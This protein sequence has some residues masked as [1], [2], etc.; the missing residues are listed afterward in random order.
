[1]RIVKKITGVLLIVAGLTDAVLFVI[2]AISFCLDWA[3][4][5]NQ[6]GEIF[7]SLLC[8]IAGGAV[9]YGGVRLF[10]NG[11]TSIPIKEPVILNHEN[12]RPLT[13]KKFTLNTGVSN[14][15][16]MII[17]DVFDIDNLGCVVTGVLKGEAL[18]LQDNV[19][20]L[21]EN[22]KKRY[23]Q[24]YQ[25]EVFQGEKIMK[26]TRVMGDSGNRVGLL[27]KGMLANSV[28]LGDVLTSVTPNTRDV[29]QPIENPRLKGLLTGRSE[30]FLTDLE[31]RIQREISLANFLV[32][33]EFDLPPVSNEDGTAKLTKDT[34]MLF[35]YLTA[36][37]GPSYQPV[38]TD[39]AELDKW[40]TGKE[41]KRNT[42]LMSADEVKQMLHSN[43]N[44]V[45]YVINPFSDN[46]IV[47]TEK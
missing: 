4:M 42:I 9:A 15:Y 44:L 16:T 5:G 10:K 26:A 39:H 35:P 32:L 38:F 22:G 20:I 28:S 21:S 1:M 40:N 24:I 41:E 17:D 8:A 7:L 29:D 11:R 6:I 13:E 34:H 12:E 18:M 23:E 37:D 31:E 27:I 3:Y 45:G 36:Q 14:R 46:W 47:E 2:V 30:T 19:W 43:D 25:A 33:V